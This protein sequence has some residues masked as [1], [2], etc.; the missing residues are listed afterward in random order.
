MYWPKWWTVVFMKRQNNRDR[1]PMKDDSRPNLLGN[2]GSNSSIHLGLIRWEPHQIVEQKFAL[3]YKQQKMLH[4]ICPT[5]VLFIFSFSSASDSKFWWNRC[6]D[7]RRR[8]RLLFASFQS[9]AVAAAVHRLESMLFPGLETCDKSVFRS[10]PF[11]FFRDFELEFR[12]TAV[13]TILT[14]IQCNLIWLNVATLA[15]C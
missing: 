10:N 13:K 7:F 6:N 2:L 9:P 4:R 5:W 8:R 14:V 3:I 1:Q 11:C 12:A 15:K